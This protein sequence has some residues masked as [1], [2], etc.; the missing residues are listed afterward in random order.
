M[1]RDEK[2]IRSTE[3]SAV[4]TLWVSS[5]SVKRLYPND[6]YSSFCDTIIDSMKFVS[7]VLNVLN[8]NTFYT[9]DQMAQYS[10]AVI[11]LIKKSK[12]LVEG[13]M[14]PQD[15]VVLF[16]SN[17]GILSDISTFKNKEEFSHLLD[18]NE[19][20]FKKHLSNTIVLLS[21][22][23]SSMKNI[24]KP[25]HN[26]KRCYS[27][28]LSTTI[29]RLS[30]SDAHELI[31]KLNQLDTSSFE[32]IKKIDGNNIAKHQHCFR[33]MNNSA[34]LLKAFLILDQMMKN[35][36]DLG[37]K[38]KIYHA[39]PIESEN[40]SNNHLDASERIKEAFH[41]NI[42]G[43]RQCLDLYYSFRNKLSSFPNRTTF[44]LSYQA[45]CQELKN[46]PYYGLTRC[47]IDSFLLIRQLQIIIPRI[48]VIIF[49][50]PK[51]DGFNTLY[52]SLID[53]VLYCKEYALK[54]INENDIIQAKVSVK[55]LK[56]NAESLSSK[57]NILS[58]SK[59]N[60]IIDILSKLYGNLSKI[61]DFFDFINHINIIVTIFNED[62]QSSHRLV[63]FDGSFNL[64]F[65]NEIIIEKLSNEYPESLSLDFNV[66]SIINQY[67][68]K[69]ITDGIIHSHDDGYPFNLKN[70][71]IPNLFILFGNIE[72][73]LN[74]CFNLDSSLRQS[75][76]DIIYSPSSENTV[77]LVLTKIRK[78]VILN[79]FINVET[80]DNIFQ[81]QKLI[82]IFHDT[83]IF[84]K[85]IDFL[86]I[87]PY[88][89]SISI[90]YAKSF[91]L[92]MFNC[93]CFKDLTLV[94][95][96]SESFMENI[97]NK[98]AQILKNSHQSDPQNILDQIRSFF[99]QI[100]STISSNNIVS[101][102]GVDDSKYFL[103]WLFSIECKSFPIDFEPTRIEQIVDT[104]FGVDFPAFNEIIRH[105]FYSQQSNEGSAKVFE[106]LS[107][108]SGRQSIHSILE[109]E[110]D[111]SFSL[112]KLFETSLEY[113]I[114]DG[115]IS[116]R[117][118]KCNIPSFNGLASI[119]D[120]LLKIQEFIVFDIKFFISWIQSL[121]FSAFLEHKN[122]QPSLIVDSIFRGTL[123]EF[124]LQ[125]LMISSLVTYNEKQI[126]I[127]IILIDLWRF[128]LIRDEISKV[129][130]NTKNRDLFF[131]SLRNFNIYCYTYY[132]TSS[133]VFL[134]TVFSRGSLTQDPVPILRS[135]IN[136]ISI[137]HQVPNRIIGVFDKNMAKIWY[138]TEE[139][140]L[141]SLV[142][143]IKNTIFEYIPMPDSI[144][145]DRLLDEI[146]QSNCK[147]SKT[148]PVYKNL[149]QKVFHDFGENNK[150]LCTKIT[151]YIRVLYFHSQQISGFMEFFHFILSSQS[152]ITSKPF[153]IDYF[154]EENH[155]D[156][157]N[158]F[159]L[160]F[161]LLFSPELTSNYF[162]AE[163]KFA[164][165]VSGF[166][167]SI[168]QNALTIES[169]N[170]IANVF[171]EQCHLNSIIK[172]NIK[173]TISHEWT[174]L[175]MELSIIDQQV[176]IAQEKNIHYQNSYKVLA[177][178]MKCEMKSNLFML[179]NAI[180]LKDQLIKENM[181]IENELEL[182]YSKKQN[183]IMEKRK[184]LH[185]L[186]NHYNSLCSGNNLIQDISQSQ[187]KIISSSIIIGSNSMYGLSNSNSQIENSKD[188]SISSSST[189]GTFEQK[190][191]SIPDSVSKLIKHRRPI[192]L[193]SCKHSVDKASLCFFHGEQEGTHSL[194]SKIHNSHNTYLLR[195][196]QR[197]KSTDHRGSVMKEED[198]SRRLSLTTS[199]LTD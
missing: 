27:R 196:S 125:E 86:K 30:V 132:T 50:N 51:A 171:N 176:K 121:E 163:H 193:E 180:D 151:G 108:F 76:K 36:N 26:A 150:S 198:I 174:V 6:P 8:L 115:S 146:G 9:K 73:C 63:L 195:F 16:Y 177:N 153:E 147:F 170:D 145:Y 129:L 160:S 78:Y 186:C 35:L 59:M 5:S 111:S 1:E 32:L 181:E 187:S 172:Q 120:F 42:S 156:Y 3:P 91:M 10:N 105:Y 66:T 110:D 55:D 143:F 140:N 119:Y 101:L 97:R 167:F 46:I 64:S 135:L 56:S 41:K 93:D 45:F 175:N 136:E 100:I 38:F 71:S 131:S 62:A 4:D 168:P 52:R 128:L 99:P 95:Q 65:C 165:S 7:E 48:E 122:I 90:V 37:E 134:R 39:T 23:T 184:I 87:C 139:M 17:Y 49:Q 109:K 69:L 148:I 58:F 133:I 113:C 194:L 158:Q 13:T 20:D 18:F 149:F 74:K 126:N 72:K 80:E 116:I 43:P 57:S 166:V 77:F 102:L 152:S 118:G 84:L 130:I 161:S 89:R 117:K 107:V 154:S 25:Y 67:V 75:I 29:A 60:A 103:S 98:L 159:P 106:F 199:I 192:W 141:S 31:E 2:V 162:L 33:I 40:N 142:S 11:I 157:I 182:T 183:R 173:N 137:Y 68:D 83:L 47:I 144:E 19:T 197:I 24:T 138:E 79:K 28:K 81:I 112:I 96:F 114:K 85:L 188:N 88:S 94:S 61:Q 124:M 123:N 82:M 189:I 191:A 70:V 179:H 155:Y 54:S 127:C 185:G 22:S 169:Q 12:D 34:L 15:Y 44:S 21:G 14:K 190:N 164:S 178:Q 104:L 92:K 53:F